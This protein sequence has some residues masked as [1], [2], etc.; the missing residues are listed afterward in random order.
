MITETV[1]R[2]GFSSGF[3]ESYRAHCWFSISA[4]DFKIKSSGQTFGPVLTLK[5]MMSNN[6]FLQGVRQLCHF[7]HKVQLSS[8]KYKDKNLFLMEQKVF[9]I[10]LYI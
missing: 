9:T 5:W 1:V 6:I 3:F 8:S 10:V 2:E 4:L 7:N